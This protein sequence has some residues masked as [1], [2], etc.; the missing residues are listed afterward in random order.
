MTD[1]EKTEVLSYAQTIVGDPYNYSFLFDT[2]NK[3]Y[4]SDLV[5]KSFKKIL[6][7]VKMEYSY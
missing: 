6:F 5:S 1:R 2:T 3:S 7:S 4:C